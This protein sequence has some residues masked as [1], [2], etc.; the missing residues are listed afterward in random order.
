MKRAPGK[1]PFEP[2]PD[3][4]TASAASKARRSDSISATKGSTLME[5]IVPPRS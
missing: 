2:M 1:S 5:S 3:C 4:T